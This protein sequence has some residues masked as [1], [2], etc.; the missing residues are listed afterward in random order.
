LDLR[1]GSYFAEI[2]YAT[3]VYLL[4]YAVVDVS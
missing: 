4:R 1:T 3:E 2:I